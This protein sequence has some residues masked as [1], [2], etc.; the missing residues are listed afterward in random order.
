MIFSSVFFKGSGFCIC[1]TVK[2]NKFNDE[3]MTLKFRY[4]PPID[5]KRILIEHVVKNTLVELNNTSDNFRFSASAATFDMRLRKPEFIGDFNFKNVKKIA[6]NFK[7]KDENDY[8]KELV[9]LIANADKIKNC[10]ADK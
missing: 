8:R 5:D 1:Q 4:K 9:S 10:L 7:G 2:S 6:L 3:L